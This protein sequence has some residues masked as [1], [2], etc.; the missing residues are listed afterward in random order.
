MLRHMMLSVFALAMTSVVA[1]AAD[2]PAP[3]ALGRI[4]A[5]PV[6]VYPYGRPTPPPPPT[7][8]YVGPLFNQT[9]L[10]DLPWAHGG[11]YYGSQYSY[12]YP[13]PHFCRPCCP[14]GAPP[15]VRLRA[16]RLLLRPTSAGY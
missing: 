5:E 15:A 12:L 13:R 9:P 14:G 3:G 11:Y 1:G 6:V 16:L 10:A 8:Y 2:L 4:F 7:E